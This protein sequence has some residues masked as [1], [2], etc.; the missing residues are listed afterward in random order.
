MMTILL[1]SAARTLVLAAAAWAALRILRVRHVVAQKIAWTLVLAAAVAMPFLM[2]WH[3]TTL[4]P[5]TIP[6]SW[7]FRSRPAPARRA[8][9][10]THFDVV[11]RARERAWDPII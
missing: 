7:S 8:L 5:V 9:P 4:R 11:I 2:R 6:A 1:E 3:W 10:G